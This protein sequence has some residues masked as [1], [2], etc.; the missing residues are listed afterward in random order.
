MGV[1]LTALT[2]PAKAKAAIADVAKLTN[3][4]CLLLSR[5]NGKLFIYLPLWAIN[6]L[7]YHF[8][9]ME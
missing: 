4:F 8:M 5:E 1:A 9:R 2:P 6:H 3:L 7:R